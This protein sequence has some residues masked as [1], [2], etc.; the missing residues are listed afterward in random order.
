MA[1]RISV[2]VRQRGI[3]GVAERARQ[4]R[5]E[6]LER[7]FGGMSP[8]ELIR[9]MQSAPTKKERKDARDYVLMMGTQEQSKK[10]EFYWG[11]PFRSRGWR[12]C[13]CI[14]RR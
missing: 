8:A 7:R 12:R 9:Y 13:F 5:L 1:G 14:S 10:P 2:E 3:D 4:H 6:S 11:T